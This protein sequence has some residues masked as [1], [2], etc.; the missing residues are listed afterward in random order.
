MAGFLRRAEI[1]RFL[2][3]TRWAI[4]EMAGNASQPHLTNSADYEGY[5]TSLNT[6][7]EEFIWKS[8]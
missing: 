3:T 4:S 8:P 2:H 7:I 6:Q 1:L 5:A